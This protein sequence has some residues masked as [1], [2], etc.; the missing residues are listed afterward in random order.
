MSSKTKIRLFYLLEVFIWLLAIILCVGII[1]VNQIKKQKELLT[2]RI[3][4]DDVDGL[5]EGSSVRLMGVPIGYV[6]TI[7]IVQD[8]VYVKFVL[9]EKDVKLPQGVIATVEFNGMAGSKS[10]E[11]YPPDSVSKASGKLVTIKK[12][13]RLSSALGLFDDM[14]AKIDSIIVRCNHFS[15]ELEHVFPKQDVS[16]ESI[17][18]VSAA[19]ASV[20]LLNNLI[21][22]IDDSRI[23]F[24]K[25]LKPKPIIIFD[26]DNL[27]E[28]QQAEEEELNG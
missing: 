23:K 15:G 24:M 5:I 21:E 3:F 8:Q 18:S 13:N 9:T 10:L 14:F 6:K 2:Y 17:D 25:N 16:E 1:R 19:N 12:T 26:K 7:S 28:E 4:M 20:G 22:K 27:E 11:I